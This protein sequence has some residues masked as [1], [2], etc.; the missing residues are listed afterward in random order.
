[1]RRIAK[2]LD[3][4]PSTISRELRR[5][6]SGFGY[7]SGIADDR[8][9]ARRTRASR[10]PLKFT[11]KVQSYV[12]GELKLGHSPEQISG[13]MRWHT[14][15]S[16]ISHETVYRFIRKDQRCGGRIY[17]HLRKRGR[18][19]RRRIKRIPARNFIENRP[20]S[21]QRK[22]FYGDWEIDLMR[23]W[24]PLGYLFVAVERK[25][26]FVKIAYIRDRRSETVEKAIV[27]TL[28]PYKVRTI[29]TDNGG[30]FANHLSFAR[31]LETRVYFCR[32]YKAWQK[33]LVEN[34]VGLLRQYYPK[35]G[36]I[37]DPPSFEIA[38]NRLNRRPRKSL[39]FRSPQ[40]LKGKI[41]RSS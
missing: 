31:A 28:G 23:C 41:S 16:P 13:A 9:K 4:S 39:G 10:R 17:L 32:P 21:V 18:K 2:V 15:H 3:V 20:E 27:E 35:R 22:L 25:S 7:M 5:N 26:L 8:A 33:G 38:E 19:Y 36:H 1:M 29:T 11:P 12:V 40:D 37:P 30:E 34:A 14:P 6:R 24:K